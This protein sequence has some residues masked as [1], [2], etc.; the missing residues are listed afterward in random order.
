VSTTGGRGDPPPA[1]PDLVMAARAVLDGVAYG[2]I[3]TIEGDNGSARVSP[4][5]LTHDRYTRFYWV[6][7]PTSHH[8]RNLGRDPRVSIVVFDSTRSAAQTEAVYLTGHAHE[9]AEH[10]LAEACQVAF[11]RLHPG[12]VAMSPT[13]LSRKAG[14]RL[15]CATADRVETHIRGSDP[16]WGDGVDRRV[17]VAPGT[18]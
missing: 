16:L 13:Q 8:S 5:Y 6:S 9:V 10:D 14:L 2:V 18:A 11:Q 15:Y 4:V 1:D 7:S 3:G 12:A 17:T